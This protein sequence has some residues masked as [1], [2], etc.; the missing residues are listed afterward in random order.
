MKFIQPNAEI[1]E[2]KFPDSTSENFQE[3]YIQCIY[4]NE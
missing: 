4:V 2:Q 3:D 1:W